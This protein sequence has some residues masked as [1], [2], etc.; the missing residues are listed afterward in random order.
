MFKLRILAVSTALGGLAAC[1][2]T[3][4]QQALIGGSAGAV[5]AV[6]LNANPIVGAAVG[7]AGN[8]LYCDQK[9]GQC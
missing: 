8:V 6:A 7:V 1:G 4:G 5:T 3:V 2:D 9:P